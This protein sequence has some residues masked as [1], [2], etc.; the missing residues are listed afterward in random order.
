MDGHAI[1]RVYSERPAVFLTALAIIAAFLFGL[2]CLAWFAMSGHA[3]GASRM[4]I[5]CTDWSFQSPVEKH[6]SGPTIQQMCERYFA[7]RSED[8][9]QRD[10]AAW[11]KKVTAADTVW[12]NQ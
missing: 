12:E 3:Q 8:E 2:I 4:G 10:D 9:A 1:T 5:R 7:G 11:Q 6:L